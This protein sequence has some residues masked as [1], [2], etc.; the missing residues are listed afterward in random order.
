LL[1]S[2]N[3]LHL[4]LT[5]RRDDT[6]LDPEMPF[7]PILLSITDAREAL[8]RMRARKKRPGGVLEDTSLG[9]GCSMWG[10]LGLIPSTRKRKNKNRERRVQPVMETGKQ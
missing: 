10:A 5:P 4:A 6:L 9:L 2:L 8:G 1:S 3:V 7:S